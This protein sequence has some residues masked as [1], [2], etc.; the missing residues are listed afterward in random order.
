[1]GNSSMRK[2][3]NLTRPEDFAALRNHGRSWSDR[4]IVMV[5][6]PNFLDNNRIGLSV[7]KKIG[8]AVV[9]NRIRRR[10]REA[11]RQ[12]NLRGGMD[13]LLIARKESPMADF[14]TL[15]SSVNT[16]CSRARLVTTSPPRIE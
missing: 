8:K 14:Q 9:R 1:M 11:M 13:I 15:K 7:S 10:L 4:L 3:R 6:R 16:L 2:D 5:I 12:I